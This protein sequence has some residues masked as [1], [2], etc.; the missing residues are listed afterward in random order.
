MNRTFRAVAFVAIFLQCGCEPT[1]ENLVSQTVGYKPVYGSQEAVAIELTDPVPVKHPGKIYEYGEYLFV[2]EL[3]KGIHVF[4]N[5]NPGDPKP[6]AF[7]KIIGNSDMAIR[8]NILYANHMGNI[9][10]IDL[11][12]LNSIELVASLPLQAYTAGVLPP[13]GSYF[14]CIDPEKGVVLDW[15]LVER[16]KMD[17]YALH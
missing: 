6:V 8:N 1:E 9:V 5:I 4:N 11:K 14:E 12:D 3:T 10:A 15:L 2:N 16:E 13:K 7:I 17:C